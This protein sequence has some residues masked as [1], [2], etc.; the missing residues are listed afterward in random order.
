MLGQPVACRTGCNRSLALRSIHSNGGN[1]NLCLVATYLQVQSSC[2]LFWVAQLDFQTLLRH[3]LRMSSD[4]V[5]SLNAT[6]S[7]KGKESIAHVLSPL[8]IPQDLDLSLGLVLSICLE[9]LKCFKDV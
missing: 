7:C 9:L 3:L 1:H 8:V 2:G 6:L 5:L 4:S